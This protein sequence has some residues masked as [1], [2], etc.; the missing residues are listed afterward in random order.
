MQFFGG[1]GGGASNVHYGNAK[2]AD[3]I[4]AIYVHGTV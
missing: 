4:A 3:V 2:M 1:R